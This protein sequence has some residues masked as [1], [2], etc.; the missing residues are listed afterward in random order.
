MTIAIESYNAIE[1]RVQSNNNSNLNVAIEID[2]AIIEIK[3]TKRNEQQKSDNANEKDCLCL[4]SARVDAKAS[5]DAIS[6]ENNIVDNFEITT[7]YF[8]L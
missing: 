5:F 1:Y 2:N 4:D 3:I 6:Q 8:C 7:I